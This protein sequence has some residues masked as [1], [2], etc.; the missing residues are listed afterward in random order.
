M[1]YRKKYV[2][3]IARSFP[4]DTALPEVFHK[5]M[6]HGRILHEL[7][8]IRAP[9]A[10]EIYRLYIEATAGAAASTSLESEL[11]LLHGKQPVAR[12]RR[13]SLL[14]GLNSLINTVNFMIL[15]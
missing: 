12:C 15:T 14:R 6:T 7:H 13:Q 8:C 1:L 2:Q 10:S 3:K 4:L 5:K 11:N 9:K